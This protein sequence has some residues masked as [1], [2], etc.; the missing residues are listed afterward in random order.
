[1]NESDERRSLGG[2]YGREGRKSKGPETTPGLLLKGGKTNQN[3]LS[4]Y[5][6]KNLRWSAALVSSMA[7]QCSMVQNGYVRTAWR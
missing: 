1:M 7:V 3:L 6:R 4:V 5:C 2:K